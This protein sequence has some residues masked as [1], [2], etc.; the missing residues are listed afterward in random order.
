MYNAH[1]NSQRKGSTANSYT[2]NIAQTMYNSHH[3]VQ[4]KEEYSQL[5]QIKYRAPQTIYNAHHTV[6]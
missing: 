2:L 5:M 6:Q 1:H 4:W 3:K